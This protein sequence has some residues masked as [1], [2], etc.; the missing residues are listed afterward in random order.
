MITIIF[1]LTQFICF[2][3]KTNIL[4]INFLLN[5]FQ[6][7]FNIDKSLNLL[8][9]ISLANI[10]ILCTTKKVHSHIELR[11]TRNSL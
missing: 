10:L 9:T 6:H 4:S 11:P 5:L 1:I 3:C 7:L 8:C 2:K